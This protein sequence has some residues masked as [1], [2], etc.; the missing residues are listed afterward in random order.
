MPEQSTSSEQKTSSEQNS[1]IDGKKR[2]FLITFFTIISVAILSLGLL[3][4]QK[5]LAEPFKITGKFS[6]NLNINAEEMLLEL[7]KQDTDG[8]GLSDYDEEYFYNTSPYIEDSDS[9]GVSDF[10]EVQRGTDPNCPRGKD[11]AVVQSQEESSQESMTQKIAEGA[12][13][14]LNFDQ[15]L[16]QKSLAGKDVSKISGKE[17]RE[18]LKA[19]GLSQDILDSFSDEELIKMFQDSLA[20][21]AGSSEGAEQSKA[22]S[23]AIS[24]SLQNLS[25]QE[26]RDALLQQ[27]FDKSTLDAIDDQTLMQIYQETLKKTSL[28]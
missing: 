17:L 15:D 22:P 1:R 3:S 14:N 16:F 7:Q 28:P 23:E 4:I 13:G 11:C 10:E 21:S 24:S 27:G 8:D 12:F 6:N 2:I 9:D 25:A 18:M 19:A 26:L 5:Q 20:G